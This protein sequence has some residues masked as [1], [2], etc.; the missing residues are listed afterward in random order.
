MGALVVLEAEVAE[1]SGFLGLILPAKKALEVL[2][3]ECWVLQVG[4]HLFDLIG[5]G[6]ALPSE[7][8]SMNSASVAL[9]TY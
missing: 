5:V 2:G 3:M 1:S 4:C 7:Q 9:S 6:L 8:L